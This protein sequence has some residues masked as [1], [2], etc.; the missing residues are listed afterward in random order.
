LIEDDIAWTLKELGKE[1]RC[2]RQ[3]AV[4]KYMSAD[5]LHEVIADLA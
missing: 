4:L 3:I 5:L 2:M 1:E